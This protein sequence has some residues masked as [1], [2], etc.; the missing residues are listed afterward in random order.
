[1]LRQKQWTDSNCPRCNESDKD[2]LHVIHCCDAGATELR[3]NLF[4]NASDDME[5]YGTLDAIR[6]T[7]ILTLFDG[8]HGTFTNNI[9]NY[10]KTY[11][12]EIYDLIRCAAA[13]QDDIGRKNFFDGHIS[14]KWRTAQEAYYKTDPR[15]R[16]NGTTWSK[17]L[18]RSIY[19]IAR[20]LWEHRNASLFNNSQCTTS[21]KQQAALIGQAEDELTTGFADIRKKTH[22]PY[23]WILK[24]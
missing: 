10:D 13:E 16:R 23:A 15:N 7:I 8:N 18:V 2:S 1:M 22:R 20:G 5:K 11:P 24:R 21:K 4:L 6:L 19:K 17:R 12:L 9:P 14:T 3:E